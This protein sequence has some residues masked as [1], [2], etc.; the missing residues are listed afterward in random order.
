[1]TSLAAARDSVLLRRH[2]HGII[3]GLL[4]GTEQRDGS[5]L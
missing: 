2:A 5:R 3:A 1:M 4:Q